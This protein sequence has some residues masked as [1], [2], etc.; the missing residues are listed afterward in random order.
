MKLVNI[1]LLIVVVAEAAGVGYLYRQRS[2]GDALLEVN[3]ATLEPGLADELRTFQESLDL[4]N[5]DDWH[6]LGTVY[7]AFGMLPEADYC[8][9][10]CVQ[11]APDDPDYLYYW[12]V[13]LSRMGKTRVAA[14]KLRTYGRSMTNGLRTLFL[15]LPSP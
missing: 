12:G 5:A 3:F 9:Q 7:R 14:E 6:E 8:Y 2:G 11:R 13:C 4:A 10:Q 15:R 1:F